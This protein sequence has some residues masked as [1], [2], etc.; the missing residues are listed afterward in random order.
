MKK[1]LYITTITLIAGSIFSACNRDVAPPPPPKDY[2][3]NE[4]FDSLE[5][6]F[7]K[8]WVAINNSYP[9]GD[10]SWTSGQIADG[11]KGLQ[12]LI[13]AQSYTYSGQDY[14]LI[15]LYA[16]GAP[17]SQTEVPT[18]SAWLISPSTYMKNGDKIEFYTRCYQSPATYPDRL[19]VRLN[20]V[21]NSINVGA[22][23]AS[24]GDFTTVIN[25]INPGLTSTGY[26]GVWTKYTYTISG[27]AAP[28]P[29]RFAF[30]YYVTD[31][32][33]AGNNSI[34]IGVDEVKFTSVK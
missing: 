22:D 12:N 16:C 26:P 24:Y 15:S 3:W 5:S 14:A 8:G 17:A 1:L 33:V 11:K 32:G 9:I 28:G 25:D 23:T 31:G 29:R 10:Q 2:S 19:Q 18:I 13:G 6:S 21:N 7:R 34:A 30:R 20:P 27:L 4:G